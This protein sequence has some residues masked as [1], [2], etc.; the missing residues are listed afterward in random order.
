[1]ATL[2]AFMNQHYKV[3]FCFS[4]TFLVI[5]VLI[6]LKTGLNIRQNKPLWPHSRTQICIHE[7]DLLQLEILLKE[8]TLLIFQLFQYI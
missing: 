4:L 1:M 8:R 3:Y 6:L 5:L 2:I 7:N